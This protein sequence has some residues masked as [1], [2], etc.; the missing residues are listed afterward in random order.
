M[1]DRPNQTQLELDNEEAVARQKVSEDHVEAVAAASQKV[2]EDGFPLYHKVPTN[3]RKAN[4][5]A[6]T[7]TLFCFGPYRRDYDSPDGDYIKKMTANSLLGEQGQLL[8]L[9]ELIKRDNIQISALYAVGDSSQHLDFS[10]LAQDAITIVAGR[11]RRALEMRHLAQLFSPPHVADAAVDDAILLENQ[12]PVFVLG[13]ALKF[14]K[15]GGGQAADVFSGVHNVED[16]IRWY[17]SKANPFTDWT[18][19]KPLPALA[20]TDRRRHSLL[21]FLY[22]HLYERLAPPGCQPRPPAHKLSF[23]YHLLYC[24]RPIPE[25]CSAII[26]DGEPSLSQASR[27]VRCGVKFQATAD[28]VIYFDPAEW[29]LWLPKITLSST[30]VRALHNLLAYEATR[31]ADHPVASYVHLM[32]SLIDT[33]EDVRILTDAGI[34]CNNQLGRHEEIASIWKKLRLSAPHADQSPYTE[35]HKAVIAELR[36]VMAK[37]GPALKS[38]WKVW[39]ENFL[40][41]YWRKK[42]WLVVSVVAGAFLLILAI[43]QTI[44]TILAYF[45]N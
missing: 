13:L 31:S 42:P 18:F 16:I 25:W 45:K 28:D 1:G 9:A 38:R 43:M 4:A 10:L 12:I 23:L 5:D 36:A 7:R 2:T 30:T 35:P 19:D 40:E 29:V 26:S 14:I 44:Y 33:A 6:Y 24:Y 34:I 20:D 15:D 32:H 27:L 39:K 22:N 3:Q 17:C 11:K 8:N 37:L 41:E 21:S